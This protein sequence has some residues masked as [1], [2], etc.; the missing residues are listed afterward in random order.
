[1]SKRYPEIDILRSLA[2]IGMIIYHAAFDLQIFYGA[3]IDVNQGLWKIFQIGIASTFL[4]LVGI[5]FA[6]SWS[7]TPPE[8]R[9]TKFLKRGL[10]VIG[11][12]MLVT[13]A[14]YIADPTTYVRFGVLHL[15]GVAILLMPVFS[16]KT[17]PYAPYGSTIINILIVIAIII[18]HGWISHLHVSSE[19]LLPLG[20]TPPSFQTV[21]YFPLIPW[22]GVVLI[23]QVIGQLFYVDHLHWRSH[24]PSLVSSKPSPLTSILT[25]PG[26]YALII[27][28]VHQ[29]VLLGILYII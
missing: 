12:G 28:L 14:T 16:R 7:R 29:P 8:R 27:Y 19:W 23:G 9:R 5:S 22:F 2:V 26:R 13:L 20:L 18:S 10:L 4:L 6:I 15:I 17:K 25:F 24:L 11:C 3:D 21:D 1:M